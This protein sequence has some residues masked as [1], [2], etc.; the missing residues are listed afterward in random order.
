MLILLKIIY[1]SFYKRRDRKENTKNGFIGLV[2]LCLTWT[3]I[4]ALVVFIKYFFPNFKFSYILILSFIT[5]LGLFIFV[6]CKKYVKKQLKNENFY[7]D[8]ELSLLLCRTI[9]ISIWIIG[10]AYIPCTALI[11]RFIAGYYK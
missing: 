11:W 9:Y 7:N 3:I 1:K 10:T 4:I 5:I 8:I 2:T 6:N